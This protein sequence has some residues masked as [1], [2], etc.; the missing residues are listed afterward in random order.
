MSFYAGLDVHSKKIVFEIQDGDGTIVATGEFDSTPDGLEHFLI[1]HKL[2]SGTPVALETGTMAFFVAK[3]LAGL[4]LEP[5]VIDAHEV[6]IKAHRPT[7]KSDRRDAHELCNGIRVGM[8][9][10]IVH[11]PPKEIQDLRLALSRRRHFVRV[12]TAQKVAV[13]TL[14]RAA[15]LGTPVRFLKTEK[16]WASLNDVLEGHPDLQRHVEMHRK[17]HKTALDIVAELDQELRALCEP[18]QNEIKRLQTMP[19]VGPVVAMTVVATLSDAKR[20]K[21]SKPVASY[22]GLVPTTNQSGEHDRQGHITKRGSTECRAMLIE[23]AHHARLPSHPLNPY[24][25]QI[26]AKRGYKVATAAVA[27]RMLRILHAMLVKQEDFDVNKLRVERGPFVK[28]TTRVYRLRPKQNQAS[29]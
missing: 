8:Y 16:H 9:R 5:V 22:L 23:A 3:Q 29:A 26:C 7:Q 18:R 20:F 25:A 19:G 21:G 24:F 2:P 14:V 12:A 10:S 27:H 28:T 11:I 6:R 13:K 1:K 4:G 17:M 15:G